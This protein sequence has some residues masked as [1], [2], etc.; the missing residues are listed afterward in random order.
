MV[1]GIDH[2]PE[3]VEMSIRNIG[4]HHQELLDSG[5]IVMV[6]VGRMVTVP[7]GIS[8]ISGRRASGIR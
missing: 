5:N 3:L 4:K 8:L 2:I 6:E 7:L 1:V